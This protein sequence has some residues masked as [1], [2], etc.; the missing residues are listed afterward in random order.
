MTSIAAII[1]HTLFNVIDRDI[2]ILLMR[3]IRPAAQ[4][5]SLAI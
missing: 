1:S 2:E 3:V 4:P 5:L